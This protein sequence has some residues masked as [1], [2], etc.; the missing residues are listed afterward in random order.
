VGTPRCKLQPR[1]QK[2][3]QKHLVLSPPSLHRVYSL[4]LSPSRRLVVTVETPPQP[5]LYLALLSS[6]RWALASP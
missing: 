1:V 4:R 2:R 5:D 3:N 6:H